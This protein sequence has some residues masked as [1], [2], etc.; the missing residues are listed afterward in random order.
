MRLE[1]V[2]REFRKTYPDVLLSVDTFYPKVIEQ[3]SKYQIDI[4]NDVS[5]PGT[6][7]ID[8]IRI[9]KEIRATYIATSHASD[10]QSIIESF[11]Q[12]RQ[13][14]DDYGFS[15]YIFDPGFGF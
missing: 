1:P 6:Q 13:I 15:N 4:I 10:I 3:L 14:M 2:I 7:T 12:R 5:D 11:L 9:A 8:F